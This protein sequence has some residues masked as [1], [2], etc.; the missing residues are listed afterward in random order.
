MGC[1]GGEPLGDDAAPEPTKA[2]LG[3]WKVT[4]TH[5]RPSP[6]RHSL[7]VEEKL[8]AEDEQE[9]LVLCRSRT[10]VFGYYHTYVEK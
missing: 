7:A 10:S 4:T 9:G 2:G 6:P 1:S 3:R 8:S 5:D